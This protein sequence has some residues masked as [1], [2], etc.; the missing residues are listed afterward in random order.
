M[1]RDTSK[2]LMDELEEERKA[3]LKSIICE[4][5][6]KFPDMYSMTYG[7]ERQDRMH[8]EVCD[9]CPLTYL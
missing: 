6:C 1:R 7:D 9:V 8:N 2:S 4:N 5:F 3:H